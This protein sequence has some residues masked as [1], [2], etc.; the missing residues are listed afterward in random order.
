MA[1]E[2]DLRFVDA[3]EQ[4]Y[5][6]QARVGDEVRAFL[7]TEV[8][9]YLHGC[10][11]MEVEALRDELEKHNP[12][13]FLGRRKL[14]RLQ[15]KAEAAR[16]FMRWCGEAMQTGNFAYQQLETYREGN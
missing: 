5:F 15:K 1:D 9:R 14:R 12:D 6:A 13:N 7:N 16:Y 10:A 8:G 2:R 3:Q 11:K 4:A